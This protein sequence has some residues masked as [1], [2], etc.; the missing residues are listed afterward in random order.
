MEDEFPKFLNDAEYESLRPK[1][2]EDDR[3]DD[4]R[5]DGDRATVA[6]VRAKRTSRTSSA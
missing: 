6:A 5:D 1:R 4:R 3:M 2:E